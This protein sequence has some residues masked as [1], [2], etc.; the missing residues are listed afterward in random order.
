MSEKKKK[1]L[2]KRLQDKYR[3]TILNETTF[4]EKY[5]TRLSPMFV[6]AALIVG[7]IISGG[8][9]ILLVAYTPIKQLIIP[10]YN[11]YSSY[12]ADAIYSRNMVDSLAAKAKTDAVYLDILKKVI[13]GEIEDFELSDTANFTIQELE[14]FSITP[15][16]SLLRIQLEKEK[17][18]ELKEEN[19]IAS[20]LENL[21]LFKPIEGTISSDFDP[22]KNHFGIDIIAPNNTVVK[23]VLDGTI[24]YIAFTPED[25]N[26]V[27][28]QHDHN[29]ISLYKH[30]SKVFKKIG[31]PI[32]AG[33]SLAIIGNTGT[34]TDGPHLHFELW[35]QGVPTDPTN[36]FTFSE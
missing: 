31:D 26:I 14:D 9:I 21:F 10:N 32:K 22:K 1:K 34:Q 30:N 6:I 11:D 33:E 16:D 15:E 29:L 23:S 18:Y 12:Q 17:K 3:L 36:Y 35:L 7:F 24:I 28:V 4:E 25:G 2:I 19:T 13:K 8:I 27:Q 5:S 20:T